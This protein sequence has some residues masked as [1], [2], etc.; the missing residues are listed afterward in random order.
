MDRN[1]PLRPEHLG[2]EATE[3][4][5][6]AFKHLVALLDG[7]EEAAWNEGDWTAGLLARGYHRTE[8]GRWFTPDGSQL[9]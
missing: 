7:D 8:D 2:W 3:D 5:V 9:S 1:E 4:D 6:V